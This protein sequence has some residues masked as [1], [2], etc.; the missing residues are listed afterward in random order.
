[1]TAGNFSF[2]QLTGTEPLDNTNQ[3]HGRGERFPDGGATLYTP[4]E[5]GRARVCVC[6]SESSSEPLSAARRPLKMLLGFVACCFVQIRTS[7]QTVNT[8]TTRPLPRLS[9][10]KRTRRPAEGRSRGG[11][12]VSALLRKEGV[13][14]GPRWDSVQS[15]SA[16]HHDHDPCRWTVHV[17][18]RLSDRR[19]GPE[20]PGG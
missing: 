20:E 16:K 17:R 2:D 10:S 12:S 18:A 6:R 14:T 1:M 7:T 11:T 4:H 19:W 3:R 15:S 13:R 5:W 9:G 8:R